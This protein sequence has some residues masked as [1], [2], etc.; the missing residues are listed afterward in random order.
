MPPWGRSL[1]EASSR[2]AVPRRVR[3]RTEIAEGVAVA[4]DPEPFRQML[5]N[6]LDNAVKYG[7]EDQTVTVTLAPTDAAGRRQRNRGRHGGGRSPAQRGRVSGRGLPGGG[8][9]RPAPGGG[10]GW[11]ARA[12]GRRP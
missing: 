3:L 11:R 12:A 2:M 6:L 5:L 4:V 8:A 9:R 1:V 10:G 7:P